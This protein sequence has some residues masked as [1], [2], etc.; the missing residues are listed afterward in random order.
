[1][2]KNGIDVSKW[3]GPIDFKKVKE[4]GIQF[5]IIR[6]GSGKTIDPKFIEY[7]KGARESGLWIAG[8]YHFSYAMSSE[9]AMS[10]AYQ[11]VGN[12]KDAGLTE[13]DELTIFYDL[14]YDSVDKA[15]KNG[16]TIGRNS[17]TCYTK[18]FCDTVKAQGFEAGFYSNVDFLNR[19]YDPEMITKYPL[20]LADYKGFPDFPCLF[21]QISSTGEV[22]G[23]S[24]RVDMDV[25]Y[26]PGAEDFSSSHE[27]SRRAVVQTAKSWVGLNEADGSHKSIIDIYNSFNG[28]LPRNTKMEYNWAWCA[29]TWSA[30]AVKLGY[31]DI[32]PIEISCY[33]L[34]E[35]AKKMK[36]WKEDDGY[37]PQPA[38]AVLYDWDDTGV[39]DNTGNPDHVGTVEYVSDGYIVVIEGNY[40]DSVKRRSILVNGKF[41]RGFITPNYTDVG[42]LV[43]IEST[44]SSVDQIA[45]EVITGLWGNMPNRKVAIEQ[46]G[47]NYDEVQ[48]RVNEIL[49]KPATVPPSNDVVS[50]VAYAR[51][52]SI[53]LAGTYEVQADGGLYMRI[54]AGTNKKAITKLPNGLSVRCYGYYSVYKDARWYFIE[55]KND[56]VKYTG[57]CH[58][59][60][61]KL[62]KPATII[63]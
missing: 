16:I 34:I 60:Y 17:C 58:S 7:V 13:N 21:Q 48:A 18:A 8:V 49:N 28:Q 43:P 11:C 63:S 36:C 4:S 41:I 30:L 2:T 6:E 54:D 24:G 9:D 27:R 3:Q 20:W 29:A 52:F 1:M 37:V 10:E 53:K 35:A 59:K 47:Y 44:G 51:E 33:Y 26:E 45:H 38:D 14:E 12:V 50:A 23:I 31:T 56:G 22:P 42:E 55:A 57:F 5:V 46:A 62:I 40:S 15:K 32:M 19:M 61:L 25:F 39:G